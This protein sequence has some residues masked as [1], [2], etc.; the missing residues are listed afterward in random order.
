MLGKSLVG[1]AEILDVYFKV[2]NGNIG[3]VKSILKFT[4]S[5]SAVVDFHVQ[6]VDGFTELSVLLLK[7]G[8]NSFKIS[9][10]SL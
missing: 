2:L 3:S 4:T 8:K 10:L 7:T 5:S 1:D 9:I 6:S